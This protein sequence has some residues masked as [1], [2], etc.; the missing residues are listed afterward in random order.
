MMLQLSRVAMRLI[1]RWKPLSEIIQMRIGWLT[2]AA[3]GF[4]VA[5]RAAVQT[6]TTWTFDHLTA[7]EAPA[8]F[9]FTRTG[10]GRPGRWMVRAAADAPSAPNVLAQEDS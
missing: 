5:P 3:L 9:T 2:L 4:A 10:Q 1:I 8:G 7:G 6:A